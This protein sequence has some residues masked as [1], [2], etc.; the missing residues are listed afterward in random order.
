[1]YTPHFRNINRI[2]Q[3]SQVYVLDRVYEDLKT[4]FVAKDIIRQLT[5]LDA[6][7][8]DIFNRLSHKVMHEKDRI[9]AIDSRISVCQAKVNAIIGCI[10]NFLK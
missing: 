5:Q 8:H 1:M 9:R 3:T 2:M 10:R 6:V 4:P 7:V